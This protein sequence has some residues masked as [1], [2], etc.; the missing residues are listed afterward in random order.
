MDKLINMDQIR[1]LI[2]TFVSTMLAYFTPTYSFLYALMIAFAFN[3]WSGMRA[4]GVTIVRCKNFSIT[5]F[6]NALFELVLY[7]MI[8][9][10]IFSIM[11]NCGDERAA[12]IIVK[13]L[14]YLFTYVYV[15]NSFKNLVIAYPDKPALHIIYH[16]IRLEFKRMLP[17][18]W[19]PIVE[20]YQQKKEME[21]DTNEAQ[22]ENE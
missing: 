9:E 10:I 6:R 2:T 17:E 14:T 18:H 16:V 15:Q 22:K 21:K 12:L 8:I 11:K 1:L 20:K 3:I 13:S 7:L 4:D 5:K 19:R